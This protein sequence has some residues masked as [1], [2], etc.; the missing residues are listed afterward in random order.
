MLALRNYQTLPSLIDEFFNHEL[1][2][3][4]NRKWANSSMPAVNI[5]ENNDEYRIDVA[6]PGLNKADFKLNLENNVLTISASKEEKKEDENEKYT[7]KEFNYSSFS[8]SF[9]LPESV[10]SEKISAEHKDGVL[11][12]HVPKLEHAKVKPAKEIAIS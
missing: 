12:I 1:P 7:C 5:A 8:R 3:S 9:T 11:M 4:W 6:A 10:D 2:Y